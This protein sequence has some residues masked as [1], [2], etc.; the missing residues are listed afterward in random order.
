MPTTRPPRFLLTVLLIVAVAGTAVLL[1]RDLRPGTGSQ[2]PAA[3]DA[4]P[5][6]GGRLVVGLRSEPRSFN[7]H[8]S[9]SAFTDAFTHLTQARL[10][11]IH[12]QTQALEPMLAE[13]W[14]VAP[15]GHHFTLQLRRDVRWSDG[16]PFTADDVVFSV[17][18]A[19]DPA[20]KSV[21]A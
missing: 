16:T 14:T 11:R 2:A 5:T 7:R 1:W 9:A 17:E 6:R 15:D 19:F 18:T 10:A 8:A 20:V 12:R 21:I 3:A 13:S 4:P